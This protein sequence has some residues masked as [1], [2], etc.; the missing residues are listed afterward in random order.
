MYIFTPTHNSDGSTGTSASPC[1]C[2]LPWL[3]TEVHPSTPPPSPQ[4]QSVCIMVDV[5][6]W[7]IFSLLGPQELSTIRKACVFGTS[8][9]EA[10]YITT[11]DEVSGLRENRGGVNHAS[12]VTGHR[13]WC[14]TNSL[15]DLGFTCFTLLLYVTVIFFSLLWVLRLVSYLKSSGFNSCLL[16]F[17]TS[18][19]KSCKTCLQ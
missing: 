16:K 7:P 17:S 18:I 11:D 19:N 12:L 8:A 2:P 9:N 6:K 4:T 14:L 5:T 1:P 3:W 13:H 15:R 10:I